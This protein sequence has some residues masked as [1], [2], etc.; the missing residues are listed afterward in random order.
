[1]RVSKI[2]YNPTLTVEENAKKNGVTDA[3]IRYYI[4]V[5]GIDR[6][7]DRKLNIIQECRKYL[8]KHPKATKKELHKETKHSLSTIYEYWDYI[9]GVKSISPVYCFPL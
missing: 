7:L 3:A 8:K 5:R 6:A 4:K 9:I 1:M 2:Q